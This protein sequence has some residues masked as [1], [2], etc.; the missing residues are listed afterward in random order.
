MQSIN[1]V[2]VALDLSGVDETLIDYIIQA[3]QRTSIRKV[4][5]LNVQK[6]LDLPD[7]ILRKY[8][9]LLAPK[10]EQIEKIIED[11]ISSSP[12]GKLNCEYELDVIEGNPTEKILKWVK[13]KDVDLLIMGKK[14]SFESSAVSSN[15]IAKLCPCS[16]FFIPEVMHEDPAEFIVPVDFSQPSKIALQQAL[17]L[18]KQFPDLEI[19]CIH[20]YSV[21]SGYHTS[22]KSYDE[23]S[24]IMKENSEK[25][26]RKF[27]GKLGKEASGVECKFVLHESDNVASQ[28]FKYA[29]KEQASGIIIGSRGRTLAASIILGSVADKLISIN[30]HL[31]LF[32]A[33]E[34][35]SN[36]NF[37]EA[38]TDI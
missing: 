28:I 1:T 24:E 5:F 34:K 12:Y 2:L 18:R 36:M 19:K 10:D 11:K 14:L 29:I 3:S 9:D 25:E 30:T 38:L 8:P 22:G 27:V 23:F 17:L 26:Y 7:A 32:I 35:N 20:V 33:K 21:P 4:Y 31:P 13:I 37:F 6:D 16:V 15:K